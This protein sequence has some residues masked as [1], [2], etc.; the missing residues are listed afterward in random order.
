LSTGRLS[1]LVPSLEVVGEAEAERHDRRET[2]VI[3]GL[4]KTNPSLACL[5]SLIAAVTTHSA[6]AGRVRQ[7]LSGN[8]N[9]F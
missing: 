1:Q 5:M 7:A 3:L 8:R 2:I 9:H 4:L 6:G